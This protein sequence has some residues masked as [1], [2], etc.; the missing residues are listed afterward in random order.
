MKIIDTALRVM[1]K[2]ITME[3][4]QDNLRLV[5]IMTNIQLHW[6]VIICY[7]LVLSFIFVV[8]FI[9]TGVV[10]SESMSPTI[11]TNSRVWYKRLLLPLWL[12]NELIKVGDIVVFLP[13]IGFYHHPYGDS[14]V[15]MLVKRVIGLPVSTLRYSL[16]N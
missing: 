1:I 4:I 12:S 14:E 13:T 3:S 5:T 11:R 16:F 7:F 6:H 9:G 10:P 15:K 8:A 2:K